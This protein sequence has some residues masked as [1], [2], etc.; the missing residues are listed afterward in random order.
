MTNTFVIDENV[1][2][3]AHGFVN[4]RG[5]PDKSSAELI[6]EIAANGHIIALDA[7]LL[8]RY[9]QQINWRA[10]PGRTSVM[11]VILGMLADSTR[12]RYERDVP[13][14]D[15]EDQIDPDDV[16]MVRLAALVQAILATTDGRLTTAL[17]RSSIVTDTGIRPMRPEAALPFAQGTDPQ[18]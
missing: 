6:G 2:I 14:I 18:I 4:E 1:F 11:V 16:P 8:Q 10:V 3:L 13:P 17:H 9:I 5:E 7:L 15:K 12:H